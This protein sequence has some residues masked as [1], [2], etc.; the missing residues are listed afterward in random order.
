MTFDL[1]GRLIH[2][3]GDGYRVTRTGHDGK[4]TTLA[5]KFEGGRLNRPN[6]VVCHSDGSLWFTD[7]SGWRPFSVR[8]LP[9]AKGVKGV[10]AGASVYRVATDGSI[11][12][13]ADFEYPNG[14]AFSPDERVLAT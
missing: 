13:V 14:L 12:T 4:V 5:D 7:P 8:Q 2:C 9:G 6:D 3:E 10:W 11:A 1:E